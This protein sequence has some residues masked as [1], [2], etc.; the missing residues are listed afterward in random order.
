MIWTWNL[1]NRHRKQG[2]KKTCTS[3]KEK[4]WEMKAWSREVGRDRRR[5]WCVIFSAAIQATSISGVPKMVTA[6]QPGEQSSGSR[7]SAR[8]FRHLLIW[9]KLWELSSV[10][11]TNK[12]FP[13]LK[14]GAHKKVG[15]Q[16]PE[17]LAYFW[18]SGSWVWEGSSCPTSLRS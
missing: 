10:T 13:I 11:G 8:T 2:K 9:E 15:N 18:G 12:N 3:S 16:N 14:T 17:A 5:Q 6:S 7:A 1:M 4:A